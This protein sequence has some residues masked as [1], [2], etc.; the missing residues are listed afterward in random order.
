[1]ESF[2][3]KNAIAKLSAENAV[4]SGRL[5]ATIKLLL[6]V[7]ANVAEDAEIDM[8]CKMTKTIRAVIL[9]Y[10]PVLNLVKLSQ[11]EMAHT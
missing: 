2:D 1:M 8:F 6:I 4:L 10:Y 7:F 5:S 11:T 3:H 9:Y